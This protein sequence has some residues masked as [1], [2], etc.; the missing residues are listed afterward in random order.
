ML[1][2]CYTGLVQKLHPALWKER[3]LPQ[4]PRRYI[5]AI[6]N[7]GLQQYGFYSHLIALERLELET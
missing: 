2:A 7:T 5:I 1:C 6:A 3:L 4:L